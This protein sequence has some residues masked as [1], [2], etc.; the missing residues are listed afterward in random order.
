MKTALSLIAVFSLTFVSTAAFA[1][2][3][4]QKFS[5]GHFAIISQG[6]SE[7]GETGVQFRNV[8][9]RD[10]DKK[11]I[12]FGLQILHKRK[13]IFSKTTAK[14]ESKFSSLFFE[15]DAGLTFCFDPKILQ[16]K[17]LEDFEIKFFL[18]NAESEQSV[19]EV[20][21]SPHAFLYP[22]Q[23]NVSRKYSAR[24][25]LLFV[26]NSETPAEQ[27]HIWAEKSPVTEFFV[28]KT[29]GKSVISE[30]PV[31][32]LYKI[33]QKNTKQKNHLFNLE[34]KSF[35]ATSF[36]PQNEVNLKYNTSSEIWKQYTALTPLFNYAEP[37]LKMNAD[38]LWDK[39]F[40]N[41][42]EYAKALHNY[43]A[44]LCAVPSAERKIRTTSVI[45][46]EKNCQVNERAQVFTAMLRYKGVPA[47]LTFGITT[48]QGFTY[49]PELFLQDTGWV[50][51]SELC[52]NMICTQN[53]NSDY[54]ALVRDVQAEHMIEMQNLS[55]PAEV[56]ISK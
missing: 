13:E 15:N 9:V 49:V 24:V 16:K 11:K 2:L 40:M 55:V 28:K 42:V 18:A 31:K 38:L 50:F 1:Q 10:V 27:I 54:V 44:V 32:T 34:I 41:P 30:T 51:V 7:P 35:S 14:Y 20:G 12:Y 43:V 5:V 25:R 19:A 36:F 47:R 37:D 53:M 4:E 52:Q 21:V 3:A 8:R 23:Q 29:T 48:A 46:K 33:S 17:K 45:F 26:N 39:V 56:R 22:D 6:C